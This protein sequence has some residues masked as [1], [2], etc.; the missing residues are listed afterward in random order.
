MPDSHHSAILVADK[1]AAVVQQLET[2][3]QDYGFTVYP[4]TDYMEARK[5][6]DR[7]TLDFALLSLQITPR[8]NPMLAEVV[9]NGNP[10]CFIILMTARPSLKGCIDAL[11]K[12]YLD[13]LMKPFHLD[14]LKAALDR[15]RHLLQETEVAEKREK[16][17]LQLMEENQELKKHIAKLETRD[18]PVPESQVL[19]LEENLMKQS[20]SMHTA[21]PEENTVTNE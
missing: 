12:R 19:K 14:E 17:V 8:G 16:R 2:A 9:Q 13:Y 6:S 7:E 15:G 11:R 5:I 4:A 10:R 18:E 21:T 3:L 20:Y 1:D